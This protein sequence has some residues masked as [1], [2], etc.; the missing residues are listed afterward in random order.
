MRR[1]GTVIG[2][3]MLLLLPATAD[4][5]L[6][7]LVRQDLMVPITDSEAVKAALPHAELTLV[8]DAGHPSICFCHVE[9]LMDWLAS[10]APA[11]SAN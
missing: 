11:H 10:H 1:L 6:P 8:P 5:S 2:L 7:G 9:P 4:P 3:L